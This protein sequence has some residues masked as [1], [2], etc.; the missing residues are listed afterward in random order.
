[1]GQSARDR[2][3][4]ALRYAANLAQRVL[5]PLGMRMSRRISGHRVTFDPGTDIGLHLLISGSFESHAISLCSDYV[6][7][8]GVV[9]D[10]G[11]NI[12][13]HAVQFSDL[14]PHG[15]V[16][17]VEPASRTFDYL[18]R[19]TRSIQNVVPINVALSDVSSLLTFY[20]A[21]DNAYSGL[22]DTRRKPI[23]GHETVA[24]F[25]ADDLLLP[26]VEGGRV[27]LVKIDVE[28]FE[29]QVLVGMQALIAKYRPVIFCEVFGGSHSNP[30]PQSTVDFCAGLGYDPFV[31]DGEKLRPVTEHDDR[32][33]NYFFIPRD[34]NGVR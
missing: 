6:R 20:V 19:N 30:D 34:R 29:R 27:D 23:M 17:C 9:L 5:L 2:V 31:L 28:G 18:L 16:I 22:K 15:K 3:L 8:D 21:A 26:L 11:A 14:V 1:M 32:L 13:V 24:C 10:I 12:G 7:S 33:Y 25:R 4:P